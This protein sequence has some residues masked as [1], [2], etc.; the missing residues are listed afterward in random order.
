MT[1]PNLSSLSAGRFLL[2]SL[3]E[4]VVSHPA[5]FGL[6]GDDTPRLPIEV[7][8]ELL[9]ERI[10]DM[11]GPETEVSQCH[12]LQRRMH[13]VLHRSE[14]L[15]FRREDVY[16]GMPVYVIAAAPQARMCWTCLTTLHLPATANGLVGQP[17]TRCLTKPIPPNCYVHEAQFMWARTYWHVCDSCGVDLKEVRHD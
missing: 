16:Y 8:D 11:F 7:E 4:A 12:H 14:G 1:G 13:E 10:T 3:S 9:R 6:P 5:S 2:D 15:T 17:C